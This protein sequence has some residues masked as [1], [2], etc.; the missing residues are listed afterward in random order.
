MAHKDVLFRSAAR[1]KSYV[2]QRSSRM[3]LAIL[4]H[5]FDEYVG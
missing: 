4:P 3:P 5:Q 2:A 1:E